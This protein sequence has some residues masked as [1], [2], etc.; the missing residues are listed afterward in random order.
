MR[1]LFQQLVSI[2]API[3]GDVFNLIDYPDGTLYLYEVVCFPVDIDGAY[4]LGSSCYLWHCI[5]LSWLCI[6]W[7][8]LK[9][10]VGY[11]SL[12]GSDFFRI[13]VRVEAGWTILQLQSFFL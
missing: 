12:L 11:S 8:S 7:M 4:L 1:I 5:F 10:I 6:Q 3:D 13:I 9:H 2:G